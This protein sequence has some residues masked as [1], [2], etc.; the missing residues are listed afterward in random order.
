MPICSLPEPRHVCTTNGTP[1]LTVASARHQTG[2][3]SRKGSLSINPSA[4]LHGSLGRRPRDQQDQIQTWSKQ[5]P[6]FASHLLLSDIANVSSTPDID[7][8]NARQ[9]PMSS[10]RFS[11]SGTRHGTAP[12]TAVSPTTASPIFTV[13]IARAIS[14]STRCPLSLWLAKDIDGTKWLAT[15]L[16]CASHVR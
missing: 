10:L 5:Y 9:I 4:R 1:I 3:H 2:Q 7:R 13:A 16:D 12:E 14:S 15:W 11:Y 6:L 8:Y